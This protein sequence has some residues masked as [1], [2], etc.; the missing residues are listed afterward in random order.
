MPWG[1]QPEQQDPI[2]L[3]RA[4]ACCREAD[5]SVLPHPAHPTQLLETAEE[6]VPKA[7]IWG[8]KPPDPHLP[9]ARAL[10]ALTHATSAQRMIIVG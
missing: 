8:Q 10:Q 5:P 7:M 2:T 3:L 1:W 6:E 4:C 9:F